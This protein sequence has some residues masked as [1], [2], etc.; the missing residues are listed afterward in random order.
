[1]LNMLFLSV[2]LHAYMI[3]VINW[4]TFFLI[5][6]GSF[7]SCTPW[8]LPIKKL[9][10]CRDSLFASNPQSQR[11]FSFIQCLGWW[12]WWGG[13]YLLLTNMLIKQHKHFYCS[14]L[15]RS[16]GSGDI[17]SSSRGIKAQYTSTIYQHTRP[18]IITPQFNSWRLKP[19]SHYGF[20]I[21][22]APTA[23]KVST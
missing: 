1:M 5:I 21:G 14:Q 6:Y 23:P 8:L 22:D 2:L 17:V 20:L 13:C 7:C 9:A 4:A 15:T 16:A 18:W 3:H 10:I 19:N 12:L 11:S